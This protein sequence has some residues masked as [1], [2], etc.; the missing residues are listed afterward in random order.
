M[1]LRLKLL[2]GPKRRS[3]WE[4]EERQQF[5][6]TLG[7]IGLVVVALLV[8]VAAF[9][10]D[11][12]D[13]HLKPVASVGGSAITRD[14]WLER[15]QVG[16]L[17]L[18]ISERRLRESI[19][20]G[21][22]DPA[23]AAQQLQAISQRRQQLAAEAIESLIDQ[24][25]QE[26]LAGPLGVS[27]SEQEIDQ[28]L[29]REASTPELR[30]V[31]AVFVEPEVDSG[32]DAPTS[33]QTAAAR[34]KAQ[35]A[36]AELRAGKSFQEVAVR[37]STDSSRSRGGDYGT[38]T[39]ENDTDKAWVEAL[40]KLESGGTTEVIE[41]AD[42]VFRIGR[43][44]EITPAVKDEA[45]LKEIE[46]RVGLAAYRSDL[47]GRILQEKLEQKIVADATTGEQEQVRAAEIVIATTG[48]AG[49]PTAAGAEVKASHILYSPNDDS[50]AAA[51][52]PEDD[53]A[54]AAAQ[55]LADAAAAKL[56]AIASVEERQ[57]QFA[58]LA[59]AESDDKGS[60]AQGGDLGFF[61]RG[62]MV[63]EFADAVFDKEHQKGEII[64]PVKSQF[65][66]HVILF[67]EKKAAAD[68]RLKAV[69]ELVKAPDADFA[70]IAREHSDGP[71]ADDGGDIGWV[72]RYQ[73]EKKVEDALFALQAGQVSTSG[74]ELDDGF[75]VYKVLERRA[76]PVDDEQRSAI[77]SNA[78]QNWYQ[79][80]KQAAE[81]DG[82]IHR[83]SA[84]LGGELPT[85]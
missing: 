40:F 42:G 46:R 47:A 12:Y 24:R 74:V 67:V 56:R 68:E 7:F 58:E 10:L 50:Q 71:S 19:A 8:L 23:F 13:K 48:D 16:A 69:L 9:G 11:W 30:H 14:V 4:A 6:A 21:E 61:T 52:L 57:T 79:P 85:Q 25:F 84:A 37:Y 3:H 29:E 49:D 64:G 80:Q 20:K 31:Y 54:W 81:D 17:R 75:H 35:D 43:V 66:W 55:K 63:Q 45:M 82:T 28:R 32:K 5:L 41:G 65:G 72:A 27:V 73:L 77:E 22:I 51:D 59:K 2:R 18:E 36:L 33:E 53:P 1:T 15:G 34:K 39:S 62:R 83:D 44:A 76:R 60:G 78:F 70:A 38:L 26:R